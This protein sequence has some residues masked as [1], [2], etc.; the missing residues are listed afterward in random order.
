[1]NL[2]PGNTQLNPCQMDSPI[3]YIVRRCIYLAAYMPMG[4]T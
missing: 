4:A 1:M 3:Y 2:T